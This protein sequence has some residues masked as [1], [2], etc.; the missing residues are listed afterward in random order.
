MRLTRRG[1][2]HRPVGEEPVQ[3][4]RSVEGLRRLA[5]EV[6]ALGDGLGEFA[7]VEPDHVVV[8]NTVAGEGI[9][10]DECG[11]LVLGQVAGEDDAASAGITTAGGEKRAVGVVLVEPGHV[12]GQVV[13]DLVEGCGVVEDD[14]VH[15]SQPDRLARMGEE[16]DRLTP[17]R[18]SP[19]NL[20]QVSGLH[21]RYFL[22]V[23][24]HGSVAGAARALGVAQPSLS[25]Q[26]R[27]LEQR[28]GVRLF[29]RTPTGMVPTLAGTKLAAAAGAWM[30]AV[31]ALWEEP[32]LYRVGIPRGMDGLATELLHD[33]LGLDIAL[34]P[35]D[36]SAAASSIRRRMLDAAVVREPVSHQLPDLDVE[37][38]IT[39][40]LGILARPEEVEALPLTPRGEVRI[41]SLGERKL[42]WFDETRAPEF[43]KAVRAELRAAGWDPEVVRLDPANTTISEDTLARHFGLVMLRPQPAFVMPHL[44]WAPLFPPVFEGLSI[45]RRR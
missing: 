8:G 13:V 16:R 35:C 41:D 11:Q 32:Q 44:A 28:V 9:S 10:R 34:T 20:D 22:A 42:V 7:G 27:L 21:Q 15:D 12:L 4:V 40:P 1:S 33:R 37:E 45:M 6:R 38:L 23:V 29:D 14:R 17:Y 3:P 25:E 43:A 31:G 36:T 19:M 24:E 5:K 39:R 30:E 18:L 26:I 2:C